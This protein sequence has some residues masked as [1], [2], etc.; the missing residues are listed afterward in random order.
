MERTYESWP[1][2]W[3]NSNVWLQFRSE[4]LFYNNYLF[5]FPNIACELITSDVNQITDALA[6]NTALLVKL[7]SFLDTDKALNPLQAS[8]FSKVLGLLIMRK[9]ELVGRFAIIM[10][11]DL[12]G[13]AVILTLSFLQL[14]F[15][16][17]PGISKRR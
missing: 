13:N 12:C 8:F 14:I 11:N 5:R 1:V 17:G 3:L 7:V 10:L 16:V 9:S 15:L 2:E 4:L 6:E